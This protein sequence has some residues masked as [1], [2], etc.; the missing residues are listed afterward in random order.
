MCDCWLSQDGEDIIL[1]A[2]MDK[3]VVDKMTENKLIAAQGEPTRTSVEKSS[4]GSKLPQPV[5]WTVYHFN[6]VQIGFN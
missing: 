5:E 4:P 3:E 1:N 6:R 2:A